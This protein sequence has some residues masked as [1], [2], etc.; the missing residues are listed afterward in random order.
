MYKSLLIG[1]NKYEDHTYK[2][3]SNVINDIL[4]I[5]Q[6]LGSSSKDY[7]NNLIRGTGCTKENIIKSL[8]NFFK[9]DS[10]DTLFLYWAGHG[11]GDNNGYLIT[12]DTD[13]M[14][15]EETAISMESIKK[16]IDDSK[17]QAIV[18][19]FDCCYS[20]NLA[21]GQDDFRA[22]LAKTFTVEGNGKI[23]VTAC[24][25]YQK[26]YELPE[27]GHGRFT[28][29]ILEG[30]KG[31][32]AGKDGDVSI[33]GLYEY[34]SKKM[35]QYKKP[36]TPVLYG[37]ISY[38]IVLNSVEEARDLETIQGTAIKKEVN[39]EI[40][41]NDC[42]RWCLINDKP[43]KYN[44]INEN[45]EEIEV[46]I[47]NPSQVE[48]DTIRSLNKT[49]SWEIKKVVFTFKEFSSLVNIVNVSCKNAENTTYTIKMKI[50]EE[51]LGSMRET[52]VT[53]NGMTFT[54]KQIAEFRAKRILLGEDM[55]TEL[56][57][58]GGML[59][60]TFVSN[61]G[62]AGLI[63]DRP[64]LNDILNKTNGK[65]ID[66]WNVTR[67]YMVYYLIRSNTVKQIEK[68]NLIISTDM[69]K[70]IEFLGIRE[71]IYSNVEP[72]KIEIEGQPVY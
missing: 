26:A 50:C 66:D 27:E 36:Q 22:K 58:S 17:A 11:S 41:I 68:L 2:P 45:G 55:S 69:I 10:R 61:N 19:M 71:K 31:E 72:D 42:G 13:D 47:N 63:I 54:T 33:L 4:S 5:G 59:L 28:Y 37:N 48:A 30:I 52:A 43:L 35:K 46:N 18:S 24:D 1:V 34:V 12:Y 67:L 60:N 32:A 21:R 14:N 29:H 65:S 15:K 16:Y 51:N 56:M 6:V 8:E 7:N 49:N 38:P 20:G 44:E 70:R 39:N 62:S 25:D 64:I 9:C 53:V 23:V 57:C 3:L 40:I